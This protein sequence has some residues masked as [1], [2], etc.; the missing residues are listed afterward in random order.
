MVFNTGC[1]CELKVEGIL[2]CFVL[3]AFDT[4]NTYEQSNGTFLD[5]IPKLL[6]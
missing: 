3:D 5:E 2:L 1:F 6:F 4:V